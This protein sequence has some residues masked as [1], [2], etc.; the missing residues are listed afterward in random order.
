M[1][2]YGGEVLAG[3][4]TETRRGYNGKFT[5]AISFGN[6]ENTQNQIQSV[7]S[8][9]ANLKDIL[10]AQ[11][12][13]R[14]KSEQPIEDEIEESWALKLILDLSNQEKHGYPL[15]RSKRSKKDP[16][17]SN[18]QTSMG[19]SDRPD[20]VI[21]TASDGA[22]ALNVMIS[23]HADIVNSNGIDICTLDRLINQAV[24]DWENVI[25]KFDLA[26]LHQTE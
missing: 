19:P 20:N 15:K 2:K 7:I 25:K 9:L 21:Y 4:H 6:Q 22:K 1:K 24:S 11:M 13:A 26:F 10:K 16:M 17:I 14:K 12:Q 18:I 23:I 5:L 8:N 3:M